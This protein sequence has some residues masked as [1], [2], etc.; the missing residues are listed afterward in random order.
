MCVVNPDDVGG[1]GNG[2]SDGVNSV[3]NDRK[4]ACKREQMLDATNLSKLSVI[5]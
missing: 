1:V 2:K 4:D 5:T 3:T